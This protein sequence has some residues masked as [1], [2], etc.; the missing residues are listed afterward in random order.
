LTG[1]LAGGVPGRISLAD[2]AFALNS[3]PLLKAAQC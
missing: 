3:D 2:P 1:R